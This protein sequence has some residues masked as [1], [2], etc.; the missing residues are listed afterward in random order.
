MSITANPMSTDGATRIKAHADNHGWA[1][2][3]EWGGWIEFTRADSMLRVK[4]DAKGRVREV[5]FDHIKRLV[6]PTRAAVL[7]MLENGY[8]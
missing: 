2:H 4:I 7:E 3:A 5:A 8:Q 6:H 1:V